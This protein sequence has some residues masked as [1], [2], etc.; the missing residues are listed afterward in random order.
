ML[1]NYNSCLVGKM[2]SE[3]VVVGLSLISSSLQLGLIEKLAC[4]VAVDR[5]TRAASVRNVKLPPVS[6]YEGSVLEWY[7]VFSLYLFMG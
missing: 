7:I 1:F 2:S 6:I 4:F 5:S 3:L